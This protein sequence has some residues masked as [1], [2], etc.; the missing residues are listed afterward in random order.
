MLRD[1]PSLSEMPEQLLTRVSYLVF[2]SVSFTMIE[3]N[4]ILVEPCFAEVVV[5]VQEGW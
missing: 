3:L 2:R 5:M 4:V 1:L